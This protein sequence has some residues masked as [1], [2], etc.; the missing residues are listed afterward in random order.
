MNHAIRVQVVQCL[1]QLLSDQLHLRLWKLTVVLE[2]LKQLAMRKLGHHHKI[3]CSLKR[4]NQEYNVL[5][6]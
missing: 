3:R 6:I 2:N 5:V 4:V 1:H